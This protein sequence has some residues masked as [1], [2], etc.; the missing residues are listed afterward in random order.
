MVT[1]KAKGLAFWVTACNA[2][3]AQQLQIHSGEH[4][5]AA[6]EWSSESVFGLML[7]CAGVSTLGAASAQG[8]HDITVMN[9]L[10]RIANHFIYCKSNKNHLQSY[11]IL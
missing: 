10:R 3:P 7:V 4:K 6:G 11:C 5:S 1:L 8:I 2:K 9:T